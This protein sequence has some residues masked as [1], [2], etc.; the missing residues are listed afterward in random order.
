MGR[1]G[2]GGGEIQ[3][4]HDVCL[5][6]RIYSGCFSPGAFCLIIKIGKGG[7]KF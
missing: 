1:L 3:V 4:M 5:S 6:S 2:D 7:G